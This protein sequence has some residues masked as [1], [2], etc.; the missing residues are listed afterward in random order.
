MF[1]MPALFFFRF[2]NGSANPAYV[3]I[4]YEVNG[5]SYLT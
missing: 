4:I 5:P 3:M 1:Y 2:E